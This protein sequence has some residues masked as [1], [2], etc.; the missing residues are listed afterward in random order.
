VSVIIPAHNEEVNAVATIRSLLAGTV[1]DLQVIFV[2]DGSVD[3]TLSVV[4]EAFSGEGRV[5]VFTKPNGG[6]ASALNYGIARA[7]SSIVV[8]IDADTQLMPDAVKN[9]SGV[10]KRM[11]RSLRL[12]ATRRW[13]TSGT[14]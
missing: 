7:E 10:L 1:K 9:F 11:R 6:K 12:P 3:R 14:C 4:R 5:R 2:D 8:C 13:E